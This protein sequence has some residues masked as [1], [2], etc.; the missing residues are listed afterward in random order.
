MRTRGNAKKG[1]TQRE[2]DKW[3]KTEHEK[4]GLIEEDTRGRDRWRNSVLGEG[5]PL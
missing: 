2:M 1:M 3:S 4:H 5:K